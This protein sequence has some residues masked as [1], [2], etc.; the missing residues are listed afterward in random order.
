MRT[1]T[2]LVAV[3][4]LLIPGIAIGGDLNP[5]PG[6]V[7][8][9]MQPLSALE[10][11]RCVNDLPGDEAA[12]VIITEPGNYFL[13]ADI[14]AL[15]GQ[16]GIRIETAGTVNID[17]EGCCVLPPWPPQTSV[18][19]ISFVPTDLTVQS[20]LI[21]TS[22]G[23]N[24]GMIAGWGADGIYTE[25][26]AAC[27]C[28]HLVFNNN[29]G[30][31]AM[32]VDATRVAHRNTSASGNM[33]DGVRVR[34][35]GSGL[36]TGRRQHLFSGCSS[37]GNGGSG[38]SVDCPR[39]D[40]G[41]DFVNSH[42]NENGGVGFGVVVNSQIPG[43]N[44]GDQG[45][46]HFGHCFAVSNTGN[47]M[48]VDLPVSNQTAIAVESSACIGNGGDGFRARGAQAGGRHRGHVTILK[49]SD[50]KSNGGSG[51]NSD[52]PLH[53]A[54]CSFAEN[55][56]YGSTVNGPDAT[57]LIARDVDSVF[58]RNGL[59][60]TLVDHGRY[61]CTRSQYSDNGGSGISNL[62]GCVI[63][64]RCE[65]TESTLCGVEVTDGTLNM[66]SCVLR[67]NDE[68]ACKTRRGSCVMSDT[69][70]EFNGMGAIFED[71]TTVTMSRCV[72][73]DNN[74]VGVQNRS[75]VGPTRFVICEC[76]CSRNGTNGF[77]LRDVDGGTFDRC[78]AS[79]NG[80]NGFEFGQKAD[81]CHIAK[82]TSS[83]NGGVGFNII[84][85]GNLIVGNRATGGA[86]GGYNI[87]PGNVRGP[88]LTAAGVLTNTNPDA[89]IEY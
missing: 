3:A 73:N 52:N 83:S 33:G 24:P 77:D 27:V 10:P 25:G 53:S 81:R 50:F 48:D 11:R 17:L 28:T 19:A 37:S 46:C 45:V 15:E 14:Q 80:G 23:G 55:G 35:R 88:I 86:V 44:G 75:L 6:P 39:G 4:L 49:L 84:G 13:R 62:Q 79:G 47:G 18:N 78:V 34:E 16:T 72:F 2:G 58:F 42:A 67:R 59:G 7:R 9:T 82:C 68:A 85:T 43:H 5:P 22:T 32:H 60:G 29:G 38:F 54:G 1:T 21:L 87:G 70:C 57:E 51:A 71:C 40:F 26:V 41:V 89:N 69:V 20:T 56:L 64:D 36:A 66:T 63:L 61:S 30:S 76:V 12:A 31:G 65:I 8:P 74:G